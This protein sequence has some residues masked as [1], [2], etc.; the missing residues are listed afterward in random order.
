MK[1]D[2]SN[3]NFNRRRFFKVLTTGGVA[4]S[5][6]PFS[7]NAAA[8]GTTN[9][10]EK[11]G[12]NIKDALAYARNE[13]SMP[14]RFPGRVI[15]VH[16]ENSV[17]DN[18]PEPQ[19]AY[20]MVEKG[21]LALTGKKKL[22]DAWRM[23]VSPEDRIGLKVN[24]IAG[25]SLTTSIEIVTAVIQQLELSGIPKEN[26]IIWDRREHQLHEAGF[27]ADNFPGIKIVGT[28]RKDSDG[29]FYDSDGKLY[30]E[31][32]IDKEWYY[33]ADVEGEYDAYT[34]PFMVNGGTYSYFTKICTRDIDKIINIPIM[35]N[36]GGSV[37]LC[38][39]NLAYGSITNTG[40]LHGS[41]YFETSAQVP[42][43]PPLR[44]K[45]VLNIVDGI[46]GCFNGGP[47]ANPQFFTFYKDVLIG[48]D[49]VAVDRIGYEIVTKKRIEEGLQKEEDS[50]NRAF[51]VMANEYGLGE[52]ELEK[53]AVEKIEMG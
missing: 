33:F 8:P 30:S 36:A 44:D 42:A 1:N 14:G 20:E 19:A 28:E 18:K 32:L 5:L 26:I 51:M 4:A 46:K 15:H 27:T 38:M 37:T 53:I 23:F 2:P 49:P 35:K 22:K 43:F 47:G 7:L 16:H 29:S 11:P 17:L 50:R 24:P 13:K 9:I 34:L 6:A 12:T 25:K 41:L 3:T 48:S 52:C 31:K 21:M 45:V 40:R 10:Q 39:K